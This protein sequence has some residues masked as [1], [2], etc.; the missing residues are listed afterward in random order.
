VKIV[1]HRTSARIAAVGI[2]TSGALLLAGCGAA[3]EAGAQAGDAGGSSVSGS[4]AGAGATSQ[5]AAQDAWIAG[6]GEANPEATVAYDGGGSGAGREQF[7][8]GGIQYAGSDAYLDEEELPAAKA[9]CTGGDI[10]ELPLYISPIAI[11]FNLP[12]VETLNLSPATIAGMFTGAITTWDDPA[13]A[14][15]NPGVTLPAGLAVTP[16][17]RSDDSGTTE[18]FAEY[19]SA[20]APAVWTYEPDGVWP[21][22]LAGGEAASGTSGVVGAISGGEGTI[23]YADASQ[24]TDLGKV[25]VLVGTEYVAPDPAAAAAV[26]EASPRVESQGQYSFAVDLQRDSTTA[27]TYPVVLVSYLIAC[28]TYPD[29]AQADL[30]KAYFTYMASAEGQEAAASNAGS[31]PISDAQRTTFQPA[32][33]A[34]S[35]AG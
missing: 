23:G 5:Q 26:V 8:A 2:A 24:T 11:A 1:R 7:I 18:N 33:D 30:V 20:T 9:R 34:I 16:V 25:S 21:A 10:V 31:A 14:A 3:N 12:G 27:G 32:I 6:F 19:L 4:I 35:A 28:A 13:I 29:A 15:E 17:N 22:E